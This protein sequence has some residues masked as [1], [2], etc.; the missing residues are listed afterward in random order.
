MV[1]EV[2]V[3]QKMLLQGWVL[4]QIFSRFD[5][6]KM[7]YRSLASSM[8]IL[9]PELHHLEPQAFRELQSFHLQSPELWRMQFFVDD[10]VYLNRRASNLVGPVAWLHSTFMLRVF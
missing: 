2:G 8:Q 4:S 10:G 6:Q 1:Q 7:V 3:S 5:A 9:M